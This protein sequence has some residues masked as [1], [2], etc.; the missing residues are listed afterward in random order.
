MV[1]GCICLTKIKGHRRKLFCILSTE[2]PSWGHF[3]IYFFYNTS[4]L[5]RLCYHDLIA[6][7]KRQ[8]LCSVLPFPEFSLQVGLP[9]GGASKHKSKERTQAWL[10]HWFWASSLKTMFTCSP[11]SQT[12]RPWGFFLFFFN[13]NSKNYYVFNLKCNQWDVSFVKTCF[14]DYLFFIGPTL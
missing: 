11:L 14:I 1:L 2:K 6:T 12:Q 8:Y 3:T 5:Q 9:A 10:G 13:L 7:T 4:A